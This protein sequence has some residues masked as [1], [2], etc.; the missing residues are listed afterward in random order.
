MGKV[1]LIA[2]IDINII[3]INIMF[4]LVSVSKSDVVLIL[5]GV[6]RELLVY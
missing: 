6:I 2:F 5:F 1:I 3:I 4:L